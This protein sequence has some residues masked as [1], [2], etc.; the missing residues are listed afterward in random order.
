MKNFLT[1]LALLI[2]TIAHTQESDSVSSFYK[3]PTY[4][5]LNGGFGSVLPTNDFVKNENIKSY[6]STSFK[7]AYTSTGSRWKEIAYGLP[8]YGIGVYQTHYGS[9]DGLGSPISIYLFQGATINKLSSKVALNYEFNLGM[10]TGWKHYDPFTNPDNVAIGSST[11]A[12]VGANL[13]LKWYLS[14]RLDLHI[15]A[16]LTHFS[17]GTSKQPNKG[18]NQA[19]M[20]VELAYNFG[21]EGLEEKY[22]P[23]VKIPEFKPNFQHD[24]QVILSSKNTAV[25]TIGTQLPDVYT[26]KRFRVYGLNYFLMRAPSLKH[27]YGFG[28]EYLYDESRGAKVYNKLHP[29]N[30]RYYTVTQ[31][32]SIG[33]RS[34]LGLSARGELVLPL[35][36]IFMDIGTT[37]IN[38]DSSKPFLYQ[39]LG[40]KAYLSSDIFGTFGIRATNFGSAEFLYWSL[41]YTF[42]SDRKHWRRHK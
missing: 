13:Y 40:V 21:R 32:G 25:D 12:H 20:F 34:S 3:R 29:E 18:M 2:C 11:N 24:M 22:D 33:E 5:A 7:Y 31:L 36:T 4:I 15:G 10:S 19:G 30:D 35:Y 37:I 14:K 1:I 16:S 42:N 28:V 26:D 39:T 27:R 9:P 41:G 23:D 8:Y 6:G 38:R 17:N